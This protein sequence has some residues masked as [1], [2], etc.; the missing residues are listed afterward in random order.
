[1]RQRSFEIIR[2]ADLVGSTFYFNNVRVEYVG[3]NP[4]KGISF[5]CSTTQTYGVR[6]YPD[7]QKTLV[8]ATGVKY[9]HTEYSH[10]KAEYL[11]FRHAFGHKGILVSHAVWMAWSGK[12]IPKEH[13]VH[14]LNGITTDNRLENIVCLSKKEHDLYEAVKRSLRKAGRLATMTSAEILSVTQKYILD[15]RP[16][17]ERMKDEP[18]RDFDPFIEHIGVPDER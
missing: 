13:Q 12:P 5:Y 14:H 17:D 6:V 3:T 15:P 2:K 8:N 10:G 16:L 11:K 18:F 4:E 7:G 9:G 1:M